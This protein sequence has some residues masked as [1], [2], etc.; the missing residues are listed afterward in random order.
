MKFLYK[1]NRKLNRVAVYVCV[2]SRVT[3][4]GHHLIDL[5]LYE[6][7]ANGVPWMRVFPDLASAYHET[8]IDA[9]RAYVRELKEALQLEHRNRLSCE[10]RIGILKNELQKYQVY[11]K[12][13]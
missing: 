12:T 5:I 6:D 2:G 3:C 11:E 8:E 13:S 1:F 7:Y 9:I 10:A 4:N